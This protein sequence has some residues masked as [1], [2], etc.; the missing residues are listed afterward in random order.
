MDVAEAMQPTIIDQIFLG[1]EAADVPGRPMICVLMDNTLR[2][3]KPKILVDLEW[4]EKVR[5]DS[6]EDTAREEACVICTEPFDHN[7]CVDEG[8]EQQLMITRLPCEHVYHRDCI[9]NWFE[10]SNSCPLCRSAMPTIEEEV[11]PDRSIVLSVLTGGVDSAAFRSVIVS[12]LESFSMIH[13]TMGL[14]LCF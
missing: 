14:L 5:L 13:V 4:L 2:M 11:A 10:T 3:I 7:A 6:F 1:V 8:I 9:V 12:S